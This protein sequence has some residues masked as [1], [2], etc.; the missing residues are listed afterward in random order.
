VFRG[1]FTREA[2]WQ[3]AG[4]SPFLLDGLVAKTFLRR[5]AQGRFAIHE[6]LRQY[7]EE[8]L[9]A[10]RSSRARIYDRHSAYYLGRLAE[11]YPKPDDA[12]GGLDTLRI[13]LDN[14]R[15]AWGWAIAHMRD[16]RIAGS[17]NGFADLMINNGLLREGLE[18]TEAALAR[19]RAVSTLDRHTVLAH[20]EATRSLLL[21]RLGRLQESRTA[22]RQAEMLLV[23]SSAPQV[24]A[25]AH[26]SLG[27]VQYLLWDIADSRRHLEQALAL[28]VGDERLVVRALNQLSERAYGAGDRPASAAYATEAIRRARAAGYAQDE[29]RG[30]I[31]LGTWQL[32]WERHAEAEATFDQVRT[33]PATPRWVLI[34]STAFG[35]MAQV[36]WEMLEYTRAATAIARALWLARR[37]GMRHLEGLG[38]A[39]AGRVAL[40]SGDLGRAE[41]QFTSAM[42]IFEDLKTWRAL[43][44][45]QSEF[46]L[47]AHRR[48]EQEVALARCEAA[49]AIAEEHQ[50]AVAT[51]HALIHKGHALLALGEPHAASEAYRQGRAQMLSIGRHNRAAEAL[52][53]LALAELTLGRRDVAQEHGSALLTHLGG[54]WAALGG[55]FDPT[56][57]CSVAYDVLC[58]DNPQGATVALAHGRAI[59]ERITAQFTPEQAEVCVAN[60]PSLRRISLMGAH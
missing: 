31:M 40:V 28:A 2:A 42:A 25:H 39:V 6:L 54:G 32:D 48:G 5:S 58:A 49:L 11:A 60:I 10:H 8:Q 41:E 29:L 15:A 21:Y 35:Y 27:M 23:G 4:A 55:M 57:V 44:R 43:G 1:G 33:H 16:E 24:A 13:E 18:A 3:V 7:A 20:L 34:E 38:L 53:G 51:G 59:L 30:L 47:V 56:W 37:I 26:L 19:L 46:A 36:W 22:G 12:V 14:I 17:L 52:A 50:L 9:R 45:V